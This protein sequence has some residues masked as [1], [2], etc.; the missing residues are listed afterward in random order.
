MH[1]T[2]SVVVVI[3]EDDRVVFQGRLGNSLALIVAVLEPYRAALAGVVVESTYNWCWLVDGLMDAGLELH[4]ANPAALRGRKRRVADGISQIQNMKVSIKALK[5]AEKGSLY[6]NPR[7]KKQND[8][9]SCRLTA[10]RAPGGALAG[11]KANASAR[12]TN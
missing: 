1:S 4:L 10:S 5:K 12:Y 3:D 6:F 8:P 11:R 7:T 9:F 2:N